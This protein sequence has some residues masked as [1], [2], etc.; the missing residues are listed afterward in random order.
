MRIICI[1]FMA[2]FILCRSI[3]GGGGLRM[4]LYIGILLATGY[5]SDVVA[6]FKIGI[7]HLPIGTVLSDPKVD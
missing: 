6:A 3:R 1:I 5:I 2:E 4:L 7:K